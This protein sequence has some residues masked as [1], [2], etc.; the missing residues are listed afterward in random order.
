MKKFQ[1]SL[2]FSPSRFTEAIW[3]WQRP[4]RTRKLFDFKTLR[5]LKSCPAA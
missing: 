1:P 5:D 4:Q 3:R 2:L